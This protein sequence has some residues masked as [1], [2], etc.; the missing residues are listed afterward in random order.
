M[1]SF[2]KLYYARLS[3][4]YNL[5]KAQQWIYYMHVVS[6][7]LALITASVQRYTEAIGTEFAEELKTSLL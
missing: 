6:A 2:Q 1:Q 4:M 5:W 3:E 7:L